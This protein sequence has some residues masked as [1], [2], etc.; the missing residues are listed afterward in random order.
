MEDKEQAI[1]EEQEGDK[2]GKGS[3]LDPSEREQIGSHSC[4]LYL[5]RV[6]GRS[7]Q[8]RFSGKRVSLEGEVRMNSTTKSK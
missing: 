5:L 7:A 1:W 4:S 3:N 2:K 6:T 8:I